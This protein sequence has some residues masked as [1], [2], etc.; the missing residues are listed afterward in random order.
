[1]GGDYYN[2]SYTAPTSSSAAYSAASVAAL[3]R[4]WD[5]AI[6]SKCDPKR[7]VVSCSKG[8][9]PIIIASDMTGSMGTWPRVLFD[10]LPV[11]AGQIN[12]QGYAPDPSFCFAGMADT[13]EAG[14]SRQKPVQITDFGQRK[15]CD[16]YLKLISP[17][18]GKGAVGGHEA[19]E[20]AVFYFVHRMR[21]PNLKPGRK[22]MLMMFADEFFRDQVSPREAKEFLGV[23]LERPLDSVQLFAK[24]TKK[25]EVFLL[26]KPN[27]AWKFSN[28]S[29]ED[30]SQMC[31]GQDEIRTSAAVRAQ[32]G[33]ALGGVHRV[34][35]FSDPK[36]CVDVMLGAIAL[37]TGARSL[38]AYVKDMQKRGQS[39][40]RITNVTAALRPYA[41]AE[42][43]VSSVPLARQRYTSAAKT[44]KA[45]AASA[46]AADP[47][48]ASAAASVAGKSIFAKALDASTKTG[49][50]V[51]SAD[52]DED[53]DDGPY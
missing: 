40:A 48:A 50:A 13:G 12:M 36:A 42:G 28:A 5:Q 24:L 30:R 33:H 7:G 52:D 44:G 22:P 19:Y 37:A 49:G 2:R 41:V 39:A 20:L 8:E 45:Q 6:D 14:R 31:I 15:E 1:M 18:S 17:A 4:S 34:L 43:I 23:D 3:S 32:W 35:Q 47:A 9:T 10:K 51:P 53:E 25:F 27:S 26:Q 16:E 29:G 38:D 11:F 21:F 46:V